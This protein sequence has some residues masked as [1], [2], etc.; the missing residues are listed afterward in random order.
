MTNEL[1]PA[2]KLP[3]PAHPVV[4]AANAAVATEL[5]FAD[6]QDFDDAARGFIGTIADA[7]ITNANGWSGVDGVFRLLPD[8]RAERALAVI[9]VQGNRGVVVS[10]AAASFARLVN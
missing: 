8:G 6:R 7:A 1:V 4:V 3:K 9:E 2:W 5:P 10:P